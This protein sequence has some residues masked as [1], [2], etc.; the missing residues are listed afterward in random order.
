MAHKFLIHNEGDQV[1]VAVEDIAPGEAAEGVYMD[2]D[3][4]V[5]VTSRA[6]VPLGHKIALADLEQGTD[7]TEYSTTIG[8]TTAP[9]RSGDHVHVHNIKTKRWG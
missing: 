1:G 5:T 6:A 4:H 7:V 8:V 3:R 9:I 2:S